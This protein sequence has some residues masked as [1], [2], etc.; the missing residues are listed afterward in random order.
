M[1][2]ESKVKNFIVFL[3]GLAQQP[4]WAD[5]HGDDEAAP[6][7]RH[8]KLALSDGQSDDGAQCLRV[9]RLADG[10]AEEGQGHLSSFI[11]I[12]L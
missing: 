4:R 12:Q 7:S 9:P 3:L 6:H 5:L 10:A 11:L 2:I 8:P 1:V